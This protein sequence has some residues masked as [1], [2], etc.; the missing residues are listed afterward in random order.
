M[1]TVLHN[2]DINI[3][4][5]NIAKYVKLWVLLSA[6]FFFLPS[7]YA[8][9]QSRQGTAIAELYVEAPLVGSKAPTL[10]RLGI[11][12]KIVIQVW[13]H[14]DL[15][16]R[17]TIRPD[18]KISTPLIGE[19]KIA[20]FNVPEL[21][22]YLEEKLSEYIRRPE[23]TV[24]V[25]A[26]VGNQVTILGEVNWEGVTKYQGELNLFAAI[27]SRRGLTEAAR[28]DSIIII[29]DNFTEKPR[30]RRVNFFMALRRG[31]RNPDFILKP[32]DVVYVPKRFIAS[33]AGFLR[34][35]GVVEGTK[36]ASKEI[37]TGDFFTKW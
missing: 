21:E 3:A 36:A 19:V 15:G 23:V 25:G 33:L 20:G 30:V 5:V 16:G 10:Y 11:G 28:S 6:V 14:G 37:Y 17:Y 34:D 29:S 8:F 22:S 24:V 26:V 12:D 35:F 2:Y 9:T 18:G 1:L 7:N 31:T 4:M 13:K 32:G 27:A